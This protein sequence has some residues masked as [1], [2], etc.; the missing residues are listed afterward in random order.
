VSE[1]LRAGLGVNIDTQLDG[2]SGSKD[3]EFL[4]TAAYPK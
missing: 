2:D 4:G 1:S 3:V